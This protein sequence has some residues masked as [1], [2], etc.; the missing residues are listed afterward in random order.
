MDPFERLFAVMFV[1]GLIGFI[2]I[3]VWMLAGG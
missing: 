3:L 2:A 1:L